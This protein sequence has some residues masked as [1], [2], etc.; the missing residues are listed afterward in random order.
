MTG[1]RFDGAFIVLAGTALPVLHGTSASDLTILH[2][3]CQV[4]AK[5]VKGVL[6]AG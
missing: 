5:W 2:I 6:H 3:L 4:G 1:P